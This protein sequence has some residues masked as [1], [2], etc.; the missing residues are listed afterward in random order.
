MAVKLH[1]MNSNGIVP[2]IYK[3]WYTPTVLLHNDLKL[4]Q[5]HDII[6]LFHLALFSICLSTTKQPFARNI[7]KLL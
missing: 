4:L 1:I 6:S 2:T 7:L 3:D 5:I